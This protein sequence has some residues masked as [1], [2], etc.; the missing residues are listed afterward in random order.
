M[1]KIIP[2]SVL[3]VGFALLYPLQQWIDKTSPR[4]VISD[5]TLY[6]SGETVKRLS[7]GLEGLASDIYWIRT[8]QYFG[9]KVI[10]SGEP[11]SAGATK[12]IRMD[13]LAPMLDIITTLDPHQ[14]RAY[15]FGAIFLPERD[16]PAAIALLEKGIRENPDQ[17]RL[18]QDIGYIYWQAGNNSTGEKRE[19]YYKKAADWYEKGSQLPGA[20]WWMRDLAGYMKIT[21]G[22]REAA[23]TIYS[24]Y[25][26]SDDPNIRDQAAFRLKQLRSLDELDAINAA[27]AHYKETT[28]RCPD[29]L[30]AFAQKLRAMKITL[31]EQQRPVDPD[32]FPYEIDSELCKAKLAWESTIPR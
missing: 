9:R 19:D 12:D 17:W 5:E 3:I 10:D 27:I 18:Y 4:D 28:G 20:R 30:R 29:D 25:L 22:S 6:L 24:N 26:D 8:V 21:G 7:L 1:K 16:L 32:G 23:Y 11:L 13:L 2:I 15:R 14:I 31:N